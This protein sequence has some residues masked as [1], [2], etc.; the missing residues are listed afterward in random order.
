MSIAPDDPEFEGPGTVEETL[1]AAHRELFAYFHD[2]LRERRGNLGAD[3]PALEGTAEWA[4]AARRW[5][6]QDWLSA[7]RDLWP[8]GREPALG[9]ARGMPHFGG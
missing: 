5:A 2:I 6:F 3:L 1:Q 8:Q 4:A 7:Q 9:G